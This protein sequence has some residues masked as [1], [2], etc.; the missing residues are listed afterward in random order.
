MGWILF[1][2]TSRIF[3][4]LTSQ[5]K[6]VKQQLGKRQDMMIWASWRFWTRPAQN[7]TSRHLGYMEFTNKRM[8]NSGYW[9]YSYRVALR[10]TQGPAEL[11]LLSTQNPELNSA[12]FVRIRSLQH[13]GN[14]SKNGREA[15]ED[16][17]C[18]YLILGKGP[19]QNGELLYFSNLHHRMQCIVALCFLNLWHHPSRGSILLPW[20]RQIER[21]LRW[22][23]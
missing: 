20:S 11:N 12:K 23:N 16:L 4:I 21:P 8:S 2:A 1:Q 14:H 22:H 6:E 18:R 10:K 3:K 15:I 5:M 13:F 9:E 17:I 7:L 19:D